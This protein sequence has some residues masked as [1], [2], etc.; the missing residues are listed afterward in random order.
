MSEPSYLGRRRN[1]CAL[2]GKAE[3]KPVKEEREARPKAE[4]LRGGSS[5]RAK[6]AAKAGKLVGTA[7]KCVRVTREVRHVA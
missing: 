7:R 4:T 6:C 1:R 5:L 2:R 3:P